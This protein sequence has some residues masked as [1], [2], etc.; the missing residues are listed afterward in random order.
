MAANSENAQQAAEGELSV[1]T[2][3]DDQIMNEVHVTHDYDHAD[4]T[5]DADSLFRVAQ[6][7]L[8]RATR[9]VDNMVQ[10][11]ISY[12]FLSLQDFLLFFFFLVFFGIHYC[13]S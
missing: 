4:E 6:N 1:L 8:K 9:I 11:Y 3:S 12:M 5:F 2:M 10:V 7:I 13:R